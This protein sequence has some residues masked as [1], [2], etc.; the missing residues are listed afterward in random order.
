MDRRKVGNVTQKAWGC[1]V[2]MASLYFTKQEARISAPSGNEEE[3]RRR[4]EM[5]IKKTGN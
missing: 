4:S 1:S 5:V 3:R 2:L